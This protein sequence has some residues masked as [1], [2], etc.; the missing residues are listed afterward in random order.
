MIGAVNNFYLERV[1]SVGKCSCIKRAW[2]FKRFFANRK[3]IRKWFIIKKNRN[4]TYFIGM[5]ATDY[6]GNIASIVC[7]V[8]NSCD[9]KFRNLFRKKIMI[10]I[11]SR[12]TKN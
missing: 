11:F 7:I 9:Y 4:S 10:K 6:A 2:I 8:F 5:R 1:F 3:I 12:P